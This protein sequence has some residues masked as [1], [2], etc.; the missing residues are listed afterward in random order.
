MSAINCIEYVE[1][2]R[3]YL[4]VPWVHQGRTK[5]GLDC[6]GLLLVA[7]RDLGMEVYDDPTYSLNPDHTRFLALLRTNL[8]E[9]PIATRGIGDIMLYVE[10]GTPP[11]HVAVVSRLAPREMVIHCPSRRKV[12]EVDCTPSQ[13]RT[14]FRLKGWTDGS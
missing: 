1:S 2:L 10:K 7:A 8:Y 4:G 6:I 3:K 14:V 12:C 5:Y 13:I 9:I 11:L